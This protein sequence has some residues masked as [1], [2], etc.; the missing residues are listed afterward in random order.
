MTQKFKCWDCLKTFQADDQNKVKCPHCQSDNVD[1][2]SFQIP[3]KKIFI[4]IVISVALGLCIYYIFQGE[5]HHSIDDYNAIIEEEID[6]TAIQATKAAENKYREETGLIIPPSIT[7]IGKKILNDDDNTYSFKVGIKNPPSSPFKIILTDKISGKTI[8]ESGDGSFTAVPPSK[9]DGGIYL[10]QIVDVKTDSVL[11]T[12]QTMDGFLPV[13]KVDNKLSVSQLQQLIDSEDETLIG[14]GENPYLAPGY[15]LKYTGL[16]NDDPHPTNLADVVE[17][18]SVMC[19]WN[20]VKVESV[21]YDDTKH[22]K[23][24]TLHITK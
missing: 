24:I 20:S 9:A 22:I 8:A 15:T 13:Q 4:V 6:T 18:V 16:T 12:P 17:K 14:D 19:V 5:K 10:I 3:Y 11:C 7:P 21:E 2:Y 23:S 1:L